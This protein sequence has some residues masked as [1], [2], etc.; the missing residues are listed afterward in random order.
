MNIFQ[1]SIH[2]LS[3][4]IT[5]WSVEGGTMLMGHPVYVPVNKINGIAVRT[6]KFKKKLFWIQYLDFNWFTDISFYYIN[7]SCED[8][9][10][11]NF[12]KMIM[13]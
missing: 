5:V 8:V 12:V 3:E 13:K 2:R 4:K 1:G 9:L 10:C 11:E 6:L 7:I